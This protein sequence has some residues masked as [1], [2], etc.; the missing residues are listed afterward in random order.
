MM[1]GDQSPQVLLR[2]RPEETGVVIAAQ[3]DDLVAVGEKAR[4]RQQQLRVT[5][6][7]DGVEGPARLGPVVGDA[8]LA[9]VVGEAGVAQQR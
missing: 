2:L 6:A 9:F 8:V 3:D 7:H 1:L 4:Q 5:A